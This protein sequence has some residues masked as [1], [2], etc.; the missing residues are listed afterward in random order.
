[1]KIKHLFCLLFLSFFALMCSKTEEEKTGALLLPTMPWVIFDTGECR[2]D[3]LFY[4]FS[5]DDVSVTDYTVLAHR[6]CM[7]DETSI[8]LG[9]AVLVTFDSTRYYK[10]ENENGL[11]RFITE[12]G[13]NGELAGK[14]PVQQFCEMLKM[15]SDDGRGYFYKNPGG[16]YIG[17]FSSR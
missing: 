13:V 16:A 5:G 1:M 3:S 7:V 6:V 10:W 4:V 9:P 14:T 11:N 8:N 15:V 2:K 12:D 17:M